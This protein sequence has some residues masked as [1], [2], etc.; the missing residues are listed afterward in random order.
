[1]RRFIE[2]A[3]EIAAD[4]SRRLL[5]DVERFIGQYEIVSEVEKVSQ[6]IIRVGNFYHFICCHLYLLP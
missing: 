3:V 4:E 5:L 6:E 2:V 1:V